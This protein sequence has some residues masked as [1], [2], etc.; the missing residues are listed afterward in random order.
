MILYI[1]P[2][3]SGVI[4]NFLIAVFS[5]VVYFFRKLFF[6]R[7]IKKSSSKNDITLFS[8]GNQ[9][10]NTFLPIVNQ[11]I[12]EKVSFNYYT[13][14]YKDDLLNIENKFINSSFLGLGTL[15]YMKFNSLSS[16]ILIS[17]TPNIGNKNSPL[18]KPKKVQE[19]AHIWHSIDDISYY[20]KGSLD[21]YD[22]ILTVGDFQNESI[23]KIEKLKNINSKKLVP[24]GLPYFDVFLKKFKLDKVKNKTILI[25]SS[26]GKKGLLNN[27]GFDLIEEIAKKYKV[28][29]RPH[30]QSFISEKPFIEELKCKCLDLPNIEWDESNDPLESFSKSRLLISD[31]SAIRYDYSFLTNKPVITLKIERDSLHEYEADHIED[32]WGE[33]TEVMLGAVLHENSLANINLEIESLLKDRVKTKSIKT[34]KEETLFSVGRSSSEIVKYLKPHSQ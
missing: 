9:Y 17:T 13:L 24:V 7:L 14:D 23:R 1:D 19:L 29:V 20:K 2:G 33:K 34:L 3:T 32:I 27:F 10:K 31:T 25:G 6:K 22:T 30:P 4:I 11:L 8:E 12:K 15:G 16:R 28:I 21:Y 18:K 26:W 5:S